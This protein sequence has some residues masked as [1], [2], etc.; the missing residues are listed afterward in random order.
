MGGYWVHKTLSW[1]ISWSKKHCSSGLKWAGWSDAHRNLCG[2]MRCAAMFL[3][4][5][6]VLRS[7][8]HETLNNHKIYNHQTVSDSVL[9]KTKCTIQQGRKIDIGHEAWQNIVWEAIWQ[10]IE[11]AIPGSHMLLDHGDC[12]RS[13]TPE[14]QKTCSMKRNKRNYLNQWPASSA[15][16]LWYIFY[17]T[18]YLSVTIGCWL[19]SL[20]W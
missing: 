6:Y 2:P 20:Q 5:V 9:M 7:R 18:E 12:I 3:T 15:P 1:Y 16:P 10:H 14:R 17:G 19:T 13:R 4:H 11:H 8:A